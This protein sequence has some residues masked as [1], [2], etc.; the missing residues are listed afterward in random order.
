MGSSGI[1]TRPN[2]TRY[3]TN[4]PARHPPFMIVPWTCT[5]KALSVKTIFI[6]MSIMHASCPSITKHSGY[7]NAVAAISVNDDNTSGNHHHHHVIR[8]SNS[9]LIDV[10][11]GSE[12]YRRDYPIWESISRQVVWL[13]SCLISKCS[14]TPTTQTITANSSL[15]ISDK[16]GAILGGCTRRDYERHVPLHTIHCAFIFQNHY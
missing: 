12:S 15:S 2:S 7:F 8:Y 10:L 13:Q 3:G 14:F 4:C 11:H 9:F 5:I 16:G 1:R 6:P